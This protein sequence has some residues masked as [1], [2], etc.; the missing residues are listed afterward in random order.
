MNKNTHYFES[1]H[2]LRGVSAFVVLLGRNVGLY[3]LPGIDQIVA[4][5]KDPGLAHL[6]VSIFFFISG[7]VLP[8][9]L[10][11]NYSLRDFPRFMAKRMLRIEPTY[12]AS[13]IFGGNDTSPRNR[14]IC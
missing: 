5:F 13:L 12:L 4:I 7:F 6:G 1:V 14:I 3:K 10:A 8:L 11:K 9:S 2:L